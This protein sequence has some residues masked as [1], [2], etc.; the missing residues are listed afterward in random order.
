MTPQ[1]R[2]ILIG[3]S[4]LVLALLGAFIGVRSM[5]SDEPSGALDQGQFIQNPTG[6]DLVLPTTTAAVAQSALLA[7]AP[8]IGASLPS[9]SSE[10][11]VVAT[12]A[13]TAPSTTAEVSTTTIETSTTVEETSSTVVETTTASSSVTPSSETTAPPAGHHAVELEIYRLTNELRTNP[14]GPLARR[15]PMPPCVSEPFYGITIDPVTGHPT[16]VPALG[17]TESVS[18]HLARD[19][20]MQMDASNNFSHRPSSEASAIYA[21]LGISWSATGENI[22]WFEGYPDSE[23]ARVFFNGWRE[24]DTGHYCA[25]LAGTFTNLGVGYYKGTNRSWATQNFYSN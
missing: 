15:G 17:L 4:A 21:Q 14:A 16:A 23:A 20:S 7:T 1:E 19:W 10:T 11:T 18:I 3:G 25:L 22:A 6:E 9:S 24:S 5:M 8:A 2:S 13:P 12:T